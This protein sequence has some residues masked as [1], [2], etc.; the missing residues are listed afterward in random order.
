MIAKMKHNSSLLVI[1]LHEAASMPRFLTPD[2]WTRCQT[3]GVRIPLNPPLQR[4]IRPNDIT[5]GHVQRNRGESKTTNF[6]EV[7]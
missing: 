3:S 4:R 5:T 1:N 2:P 7:S 6:K